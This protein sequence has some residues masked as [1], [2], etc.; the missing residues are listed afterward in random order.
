MKTTALDN[1]DADAKPKPQRRV[2]VIFRF[3]DYATS[4]NTA[5]EQLIIDEFRKIGASIT[6]A[7]IPFEAKG[8]SNGEAVDRMPLSDEKAKILKEATQANCVEV[9]LHGYI[10][11]SVTSGEPAE[12]RTLGFDIQ[13]LRLQE[14]KALLESKT[15]AI[16]TTFV[17][18]WNEHDDDTLA[19]LE[20]TG[21]K[22]LS[23][24]AD[25]TIN[26]RSS[27]AFLPATSG[28]LKATEAVKAA[29]LQP[30]DNIVVIL[31]HEYDFV[32]IDNIRGHMSIADFVALMNWIARQS[33][34]EILSFSQ[35]LE[36]GINLTL[37]RYKS[38][39]R[40]N[41]LARLLPAT[42]ISS[43]NGFYH[44]GGKIY[45]QLARKTGLMYG[46]LAAI[47][48]VITFT[49]ANV[50]ILHS[51]ELV[52]AMSIGSVFFALAIVYRAFRYL[53]PF[54]RGVTASALAVG[55]SVGC[56]SAALSA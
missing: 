35:A 19:A 48:F 10:H 54:K 40:G 56:L 34:V 8:Y 37:K 49:F 13:K 1:R 44:D 11:A 6:F 33:D 20:A 31:F 42:W 51:K 14:G 55:A 46:F 24:R 12:F 36:Q 2:K 22:V 50:L 45:A 53:E 23:A 25:A 27:L 9:A 15:G 38:N 21:F 3:D 29:R 47:S 7:V 16:V 41:V 5:L 18:P 30:G 26:S 39:L 28:I 32:E 52:Q 43:Y 4:S 17:P